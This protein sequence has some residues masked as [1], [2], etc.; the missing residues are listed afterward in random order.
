MTLLGV[1]SQNRGRYAHVSVLEVTEV[2][3]MDLVWTQSV[4]CYAT[5]VRSHP[6]RT[7]S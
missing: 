3:L 5:V 1:S 4:Q 7:Q 2:N 6:V